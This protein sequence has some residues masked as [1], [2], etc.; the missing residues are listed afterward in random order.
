MT[1]LYQ[2]GSKLNLPV[3]VLSFGKTTLIPFVCAFLKSKRKLEYVNGIYS[4][5]VSTLII[6]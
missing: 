4:L 5:Y 6:N 2:P 3:S 1:N